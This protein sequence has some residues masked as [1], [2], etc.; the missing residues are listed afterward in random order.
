MHGTTYSDEV[1]EAVIIER[2]LSWHQVAA[3]F[4]DQL[5]TALP[6]DRRVKPREPDSS[7][8]PKA[9]GLRSAGDRSPKNHL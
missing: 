1:V 6:R 9:D 4:S 8:R 7:V 2:G 3:Q 5:G